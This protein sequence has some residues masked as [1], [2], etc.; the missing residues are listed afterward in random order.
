MPPHGGQ[1]ARTI[2]ESGRG[3]LR[4][5]AGL[6]GALARKRLG[7]TARVGCRL[8]AASRTL[9]LRATARRPTRSVVVESPGLD[10]RGSRA[11]WAHPG[12]LLAASGGGAPVVDHLQHGSGRQA[13]TDGGGPRARTAAP[14]RSEERR[15][16]ARTAPPAPARR[17]APG[18]GLAPIAEPWD[19][20]A[21]GQP[22][23]R[24]G[25]G[26]ALGAEHRPAAGWGWLV[27]AVRVGPMLGGGC[28]PG[29]RTAW[30]VGPRQRPS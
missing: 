20:S 5:P 4:R 15:T 19:R 21:A 27:D 2:W 29:P 28:A 22:A 18:G 25:A 10:L 13:G 23:S 7:T 30:G 24:D 26:L 9:L 16:D 8:S 3:A 17:P 11:V 1:P 12:G 6:G 14:Q